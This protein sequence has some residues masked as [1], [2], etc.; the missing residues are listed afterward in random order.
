MFH[1]HYLRFS[2]TKQNFEGNRNNFFI[3]LWMRAEM[4]SISLKVL[5]KHVG[6]AKF[7]ILQK[8]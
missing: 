8:I 4:V 1:F 6:I 7:K 2:K 5:E 3:A